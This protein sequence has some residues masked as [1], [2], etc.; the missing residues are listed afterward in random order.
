MAR[1]PQR[2]WSVILQQAWNLRL[3]DRQ[4]YSGKGS[5]GHS[6]S[7][8]R[9]EI[10]FRFNVGK[11]TRAQDVSLIIDVESVVNTDTADI[12]VDKY[13]TE[14]AKINGIR[15][16]IDM[17]DIMTGKTD[18]GIRGTGTEEVVWVLTQLWQP[19]NLIS[20]N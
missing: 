1:H 12:I 20:L 9:R 16:A 7:L 10:C 2:S 14:T 8:K 13:M 19:N 17:T 3:K 4:D 11:C 6:N 5:G 15:M 18:K